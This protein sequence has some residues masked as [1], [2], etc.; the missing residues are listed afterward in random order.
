M[1]TDGPPVMESKLE[2]VRRE[3][4]G[5]KAEIDRIAKAKLA[6]AEPIHQK[7]ARTIAREPVAAPSGP[8][9]GA[10]AVTAEAAAEE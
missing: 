7:V 3:E 5:K 2:E 1:R 8:I 4:V 6:I 10:G 9:G